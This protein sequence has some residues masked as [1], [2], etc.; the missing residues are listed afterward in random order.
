MVVRRTGASRAP[1]NDS[2]QLLQTSTGSGATDT[3]VVRS[4]GTTLVVPRGSGALKTLRMRNPTRAGQMKTVIVRAG[5]STV[6]I[7]VESF[8]TGTVI[9]G[10]TNN[11]IA[12][13]TGGA[14]KW[15]RLVAT[16]T[17]AVPGWALAARSTGVT[18]SATSSPY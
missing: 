8:T 18:L 15:V 5:N 9:G 11:S 6:P 12:F 17:A 10:T 16:G 13:T 7:T 1:S 3:G 2:Y 4:Y 14:D